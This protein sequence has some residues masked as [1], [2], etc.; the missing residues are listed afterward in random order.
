[1]NA[2]AERMVCFSTALHQRLNPPALISALIEN[3]RS[4]ARSF[5][6]V[7]FFWQEVKV[8]SSRTVEII[9][10]ENQNGFGIGVV[11]VV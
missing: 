3:S 7:P 6:G 9:Q 2:L 10:D 1:L 5:G 4:I 8:N 11:F